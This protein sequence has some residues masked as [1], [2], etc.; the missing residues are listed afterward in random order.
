MKRAHRVLRPLAAATR[1]AQS[2]IT[3]VTGTV[4]AVPARA[5]AS[6]LVVTRMP[7]G[8][9][10]EAPYVEKPLQPVVTGRVMC[11]IHCLVV[12]AEELLAL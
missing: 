5:A 3:S 10:G 9:R 7:G 12:L 1:S 2:G 4:V 6:S 11:S 8:D